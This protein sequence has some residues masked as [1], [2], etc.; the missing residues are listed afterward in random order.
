MRGADAVVKAL[1][2]FGVRVA[3]GVPGG[4]VLALFDAVS[5]Y[6]GISL[7]L[8][9]HEQGAGHMAEGYARAS[10]ELGVVLVTS[11]PGAS[12]TVTPLANAYLDSTPLLVLS[13]GVS[14]HLVGRDVFQELDFLGMTFQV[15]KAGFSVRSPSEAYRDVLRACRLAVS[16]RRGPVAVVLPVDV[17]RGELSEL[18]GLID[19]GGEEA[20]GASGAGVDADSFRSL[21]G[22]LRGARRPLVLVGGGAKEARTSR[23]LLEFAKREMLPVASTLMGKG[24]FPEDEELSLGMVGMHGRACANM[25]LSRADLVL[26]LGVRFSDRSVGV[27]NRLSSGARLIQV[28]LDPVELG[29]NLEVDLPIL[30]DASGLLAALL[31]EGPIRRSSEGAA[32]LDEIRFW[33]EKEEGFWSSREATKAGI[34]PFAIFRELNEL[35]SRGLPM[36]VVTEV[37]Q[38]QMWAAY[39][40]RALGTD[41]FITS[42]GLGTMGFGFP[43]S[44]GAKIAAPDREVVCVAGDGSFLMN[45]QEMSTVFRYGVPVKILLLNNRGLGMVRQHQRLFAKGRVFAST[46]EKDHDFAAIAS[47]FGVRAKRV[48][49]PSE[50]RSSL[51]ELLSQ[52]GP[53]L[54]EIKISE[55]EMAFPMVYPGEDVRHIRMSPETTFEEILYL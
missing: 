34:S 25:A 45:L 5:S 23:L 24:A 11:G 31:E 2:D 20:P 29:K 43:A 51:E 18:P 3:F 9:A 39:H 44:I 36:T 19:V 30:G 4:T 33:K 41:E 16:H 37:G 40:Y 47:A 17:Q 38:C 48:V 8:C 35:R 50:L 52:E 26:A 49:E 10:G 42:G 21:V 54:L 55:E 1:A 53:S 6:G 46:Y 22:L 15:T 28:D 12:N 13:G 32:W 7:Y 14:Q 27:R